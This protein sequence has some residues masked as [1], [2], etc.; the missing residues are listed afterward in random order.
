MRKP[1]GQKNKIAGIYFGQHECFH[2]ISGKQAASC[3]H[4]DISGKNLE[5]I[6]AEMGIILTVLKTNPYWFVDNINIVLCK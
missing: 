2:M 4:F 1:A 6:Y 5:D 3:Q